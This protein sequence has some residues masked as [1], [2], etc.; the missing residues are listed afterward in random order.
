MIPDDDRQ[1]TIRVSTEQTHV[2]PTV[3]DGFICL[4]FLVFFTSIM[5]LIMSPNIFTLKYNS[6]GC[7]GGG[8][9]M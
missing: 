4:S 2:E 1:C 3:P 9:S 5:I 7:D 8:P 6:T